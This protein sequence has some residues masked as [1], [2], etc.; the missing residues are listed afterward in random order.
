M[1]KILVATFL[2]GLGAC[3]GGGLEKEMKSW[4]DK[5]CACKDATCAEKTMEDYRS[6]Q[7]GKKDAAKDL[8]KDEIGKLVAIEGELKA[9]RNKLR[10]AAEGDKKPEG[11][12]PPADKPADPAA[13]PA[14]KPADPK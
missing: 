13:A 14:D 4:K 11:A 9:C 10:D 1:R 7:K 5:M 2:L 12:A 3:G 6:W 8:S